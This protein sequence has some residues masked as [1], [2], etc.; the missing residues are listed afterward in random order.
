MEVFFAQ[1]ISGIALGGTYALLVTG[2]NLMLLVARIYHFAYPHIVV[3]SMYVSWMVL[4]AT[5]DNLVLGILAAIASAVGMSIATEGFFRGTTKRGAT[6][7]SV[8]MAIGMALIITDTQSHAIHGGAPISFPVALS[9]KEALIKYGIATINAGQLAAILG[10]VGAVAGLMYLL[11]RTKQGRAF[12]AIAQNMF[13]A[14]LTGIPILRTSIYSYAMAGLLGGIT[15]VFLAMSIGMASARLGD[16][17]TVKVMT[18]MIFAG[19]GN[20]RGG[21]ICA[22]IIGLVEGFVMGYLPGMW[23]DA[24]AF[25]VMIIGIIIRPEGVFGS[26]A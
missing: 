15:A 7:M 6:M 18:V 1:L 25:G 2:M 4:Q 12:R 24:V 16:V 8:F 9:G 21:I 22:F 26:R 14:R 5:G 11:Y 17:L 3:M 10:C 19:L 23:T 20:L 13:V